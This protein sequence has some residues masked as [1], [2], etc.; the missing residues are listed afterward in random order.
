MMPVEVLSHLGKDDDDDWRRCYCALLDR[1]ESEKIARSMGYYA[2]LSGVFCLDRHENLQTPV[3]QAEVRILTMTASLT[4]HGSGRRRAD[5]R[6]QNYMPL[7]V[8]VGR[9]HDLVG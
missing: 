8:H 2:S 3:R 7:L 1:N 6:A 5:E 9:L 4:N